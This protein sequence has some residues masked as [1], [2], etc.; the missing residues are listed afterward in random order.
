[1]PLTNPPHS[2]H[3]LLTLAEQVVWETR[4]IF[5]LPD[6]AV[7]CTAVRVPTLRAHAEAIVVETEKD[8]TPDQAREILAAAPGVEVVDDP[9]ALVYVSVYFSIGSTYSHIFKSE[10]IFSG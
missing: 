1:L 3:S 8:V 2:L 10:C 5:G 7:S 4:K 6:L 9:A